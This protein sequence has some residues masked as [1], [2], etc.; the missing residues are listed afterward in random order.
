MEFTKLKN[1]DFDDIFLGGVGLQRVDD[2]GTIKSGTST[3]TGLIRSKT[4]AD[5][6][7]LCCFLPL[8]VGL[9]S[10][11]FYMDGHVGLC[12]TI[13]ENIKMGQ[14]KKD[15]EFGY[16]RYVSNETIL[17]RTKMGDIG[18]FFGD[19]EMDEILWNV[20]NTY[21][22]P[23]KYYTCE[24][25]KRLIGLTLSIPITTYNEYVRARNKWYNDYDGG[26]PHR[27]LATE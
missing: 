27:V 2:F 13:K 23:V 25:E 16:L 4:E 3:M 21:T 12:G 19:F 7:K 22:Y 15:V 11:K 6:M 1:S 17:N 24:K 10:Y 20:N 18:C 9:N 26:E 8:R 5:E 14:H